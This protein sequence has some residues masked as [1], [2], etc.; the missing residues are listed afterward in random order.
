MSSRKRKYIIRDLREQVEV[1]GFLHILS[2]ILKEDSFTSLEKVTN[3]YDQRTVSHNEAAYLLGLL[4]NNWN[5]EKSLKTIP[6]SS[7][8]KRANKIRDLLEELHRTYIPQIDLNLPFGFSSEMTI[9]SIF[10]AESGAYDLQFIENVPKIYRYDLDYVKKK[11]G[12][13]INAIEKVF[14]LILN[15]I[16]LLYNMAS[17]YKS[18][19]VDELNIKDAQTA[20]NLF[21]VTPKELFLQAKATKTDVTLYDIETFFRLF[22]YDGQPQYDNYNGIESHNI[23][24]EKPLIHLREDQ[25]YIYSCVLLASAIYEFPYF[26]TQKYPNKSIKGIGDAL[27]DTTFEYLLPIFGKTNIYKNVNIEIKK[28][29]RVTDIDVLAICDDSAVIVQCKN[30]RLTSASRAG[31]INKIKDDFHKAIQSP[32]EQGLKALNVIMGS[33]QYTMKS[34]TGKTISIPKTIKNAFILCISGDYFPG[35]KFQERELLE[36]KNSITPT[37]M[38]IFD[39]ELTTNY[40]HNP[41]DFMF[42]LKKRMGEYGRIITD[43]EINYL[44]YYLESDF[45][46]ERKNNFIVLHNDFE[47]NFRR[48]FYYKQLVGEHLPENNYKFPERPF[49]DN[50]IKLIENIE[51]I[52]SDFS[53]TDISFYL[54]NFPPTTAKTITDNIARAQRTAKKGVSDFSLIHRDNDNKEIGGFTY[55]NGGNIDIVKKITIALGQK[56]ADQSPNIPWLAVGYANKKLVAIYFAN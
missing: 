55:V 37:Q 27:E 53:K 12:F 10:Y 20:I 34:K 42:Y 47:W 1:D 18:E 43:N 28:G 41:Y 50:Y 9:E 5:M 48:D 21:S 22:S 40:L 19:Q 49:P 23:I 6:T 17:N 31:D 39:L 45:S 38:S 2:N 44:G 51:K 25:Y 15:R 32:Y 8:K 3:E 56:H 33:N 46:G 52:D 29:Q 54:R 13:D 35:N 26:Y 36:I 14:R 24:I 4:A 7:I 16:N 11:S 30:K